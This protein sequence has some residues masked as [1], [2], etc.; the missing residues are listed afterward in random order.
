MILSMIIAGMEG[1]YGEGRIREGEESSRPG[2]NQNPT[3]S[4]EL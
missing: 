4:N 1:E 3:M 2:Q